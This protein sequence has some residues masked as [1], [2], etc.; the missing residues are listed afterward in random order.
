MRFSDYTHHKFTS[1]VCALGA[2]EELFVSYGDALVSDGVC[3][4]FNKKLTKSMYLTTRRS[5]V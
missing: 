4:C 1:K 2:G 5:Q 3:K